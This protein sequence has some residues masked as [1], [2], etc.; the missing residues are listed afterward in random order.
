MPGPAVSVPHGVER[1]LENFD[2]TL[3]AGANASSE[4]T[5]ETLNALQ[6]SWAFLGRVVSS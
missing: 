2:L 6:P 5:P 3:T 1:S 4:P